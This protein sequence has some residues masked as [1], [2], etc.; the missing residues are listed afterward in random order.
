MTEFLE[1][2]M[3]V[4]FGFAWP[5]AILKSLRARSA[6]GKSLAF[7]LII[8]FGYCCGIASKFASG[9]VTYVVFF[10]I[11]NL[12]AVCIDTALYFRNRRLDQLSLVIQ[13]VPENDIAAATRDDRPK[14]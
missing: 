3:M 14:E 13:P 6:R 11:L 4:S 2:L 5:T 9:N 8:I 7:L 1:V 12:V 10:Y